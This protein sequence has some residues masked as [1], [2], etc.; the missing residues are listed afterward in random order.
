MT[1]KPSADAKPGG[2]SR[3]KPAA[4]AAP[5]PEAKPVPLETLPGFPEMATVVRSKA[6]GELHQAPPEWA[7]VA[8]AGAALGRV[9]P[10]STG[11]VIIGR[12]PDAGV[13]LLDGEV[14]RH[15]AQVR[16]EENRIQLEDL[17]STN[18]TRVNGEAVRGP[19]ELKAGDRLSMGGHV[20]KVVC[21]DSLERAFH[22]TLLDLSTKDALTGL[23]NR[24][25]SLAEFQ[26]RFGLSLRYGRPLSVVVCDLDHFKQVN[27]TFGHGAGDVVLRAF[28]ERL[29][30]TLREAD[31]AGRIGG[32][33]FLMVLPETDLVGARPFAE[34]LR[35]I[36]AST[37]I[38]LASGPLNISCSLG[39]AERTASDL[40]AGQLLARADA[41]LYRAK[42]GGRNQV[43]EG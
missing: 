17:G 15:H 29:L 20:L 26:N 38:P 11:T 43:C 14:S 36:I 28:G 7:L 12:A 19:L 37:P 23:A 10:L 18:G 3:P 22:E 41:A 34:R 30:T 13:T 33:E 39:I 6:E 42:A 32:E 4:G 35:R 2:M 1:R 8:Y 31:L 21:L 5:G 24:G 9:F 40:E 25:S 16:V 27:D